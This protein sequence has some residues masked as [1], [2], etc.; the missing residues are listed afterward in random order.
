MTDGLVVAALVLVGAWLAVLTLVAVLV[1]RQIG[2]LTVR[3]SVAG[4]AAALNADGIEVGSRL[5]EPVTSALPEL[6]EERTS[7]VLMLSAN[8]E[9]CREL[10]HDLSGHL[11]EEPIVALVPGKEELA[12]QVAEMLPPAVKT[13]LD[14][15]ADELGQALDIHSTP[16]VLEVRGGVVTEKSYVHDG[17]SDFLAFIRGGDASE[18]TT[19]VGW[20]TTG[21]RR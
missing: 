20:E 1:V 3:L 18:R 9:P 21:E 19:G 17:V 7:Y 12:E 15:L 11:L 14:P 5:P 16:F 4:R 6:N 2:L 10:A 13:V 8:C